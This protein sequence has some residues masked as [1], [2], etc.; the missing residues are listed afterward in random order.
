MNEQRRQ[1]ESQMKLVSMEENLE[2]T[3]QWLDDTQG[4]QKS[5]VNER[6]SSAMHLS[7]QVEA[8]CNHFNDPNI[9]VQNMREVEEIFKEPVKTV[10]KQDV[11]SNIMGMDT[12]M[13]TANLGETIEALGGDDFPKK[14]FTFKTS[15]HGTGVAVAAILQQPPSRLFT[16][17]VCM[18]ECVH[19]RNIIQH[20]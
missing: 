6:R 3:T 5:Q 20:W 1:E 10:R 2:Q 9:S 7:E 15:I 17:A 13:K 14:S 16:M 11:T 4:R 8:A 19:V 18:G 12:T